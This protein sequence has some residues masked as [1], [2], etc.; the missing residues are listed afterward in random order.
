M[1]NPFSPFK[2]NH[3]IPILGRAFTVKSGFSTTMITCG[4]GANEPILLIASN[5]GQCPSCKKL[6]KVNEF[7]FD[8]NTGQVHTQIGYASPQDVE[9]EAKKEPVLQ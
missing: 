9:Q 6:F 7:R 5:P 8:G 4:C 1:S 2:S 3:N